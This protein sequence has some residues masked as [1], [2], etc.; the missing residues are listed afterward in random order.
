M[1]SSNESNVEPMSTGMLEDIF[2]GNQSHP[3][4][5]R[6]RACYKIRDCIK[7]SQAEWKGALLSMRNMFKGL[8]KLFRAAVNEIFQVLPILSESVLEVFISFQNL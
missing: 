4:V 2:D 7:R 6:R 3:S 8:H 5:N 1:P